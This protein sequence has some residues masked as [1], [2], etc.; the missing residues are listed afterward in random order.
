M[1][2]FII[3]S[4]QR[5]GSGF[6]CQLLN[7][8]GVIANVGEY[9]NPRQIE[10]FSEQHE[11]PQRES[12]IALVKKRKEIGGAV[13]VKIHH[14]NFLHLSKL[15]DL[16]EVLPRKVILT[17]RNDLIAQA[18][19][20]ARARQTKSFSSSMDPVAIPE[21]DFREISLAAHQLQNQTVAW[22][23]ILKRA[24][25]LPFRVGYEDL[26]EQPSNVIG[27]ILGHLGLHAAREVEPKKV[28]NRIQRDH[29]NKLWANRFQKESSQNSNV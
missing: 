2:D 23:R 22:N 16:S 25:V 26:C 3:A 14:P 9:L 6:L 11:L 27:S 21:Y 28:P 5:T 8:T 7:Q 17:E 29:Q 18:V 19:S 13:G 20:L 12:V 10:L 24:N 15:F 4:T 1:F